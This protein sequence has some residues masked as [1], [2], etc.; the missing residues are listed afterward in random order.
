MIIP[1]QNNLKVHFAGCENI[2]NLKVLNLFEAN[3]KLYTA[4]P[5]IDRIVNGKS[6][7]PIMPCHLSANEIPNFVYENSKHSIQD[8]GLF[9]L[10][11]GSKKGTVN[12]NDIEK[13]YN[14]LLQHTIESGYKGTCVEV[15]CQKLFGVEL[16]WEYRERLKKDL[17][18]NRQMNVFHIEDGQKGLDKMI[19]FSD[20]IAISIPELRFLKK[21]D[22]AT[23][24]ANYIK[25][26]KPEIDIHLLGCTDGKMLKE[27]SF[28]SSSDSTSWI[29]PSRY[30]Y[31]LGRKVSTIDIKK[32]LDILLKDKD[33]TDVLKWR[34]KENL[35]ML[36]ISVLECLEKYTLN[37]GS[38][39]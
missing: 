17:P 8:S 5:F 32:T 39:K 34:S 1:Q 2:P 35:A 3:Y 4:F 15:D 13:W 23:K 21:K 11:F 30:G 37:A 20:Y 31:V 24:I 19:E 33:I 28:C 6:T 36:S 10:M 25:N 9:S 12:Q 16:A 22:H 38:Q 26:K 7:F 29:S 14:G 18:N 27:L